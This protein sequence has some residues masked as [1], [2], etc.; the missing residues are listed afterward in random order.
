MTLNTLLQIIILAVSAFGIVAWLWRLRNWPLRIA[1]VIALSSNATFLI[2]R[3]IGLFTSSE[4][5]LFSLVRILLLVILISSVPF[6]VHK[7]NKK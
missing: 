6:S 4:L 2:V 5:N 7:D 1:S 3:E